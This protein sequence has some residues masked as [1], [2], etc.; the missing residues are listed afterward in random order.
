MSF[1]LAPGAVLFKIAGA[2]L[3]A[4]LPLFTVYLAAQTTTEL[5]NAYNGDSSAGNRALMLVVA[6]IAV[7]LVSVVWSNFNS[8]AQAML[9]YKV[10]L[11]VSDIMYER[12]LALDFWRYEDKAT[13]D[14]YDKAKR[15]SVFY[16]YVFDQLATILSDIVGMVSAIVA[17][18]LVVPWIALI[19]FV[20]LIPGVY[21]QFKLSRAQVEQW[22][23]NVTARRAQSNIEW[24]LL[25]P[26]NIVELRL[27][28]IVRFML[29]LRAKYR[30]QDER[31]RLQFEKNYL[32]KQIMS[33]L[34]ESGA[35]LISLIW[36]TL[37]IITH[38]Q[39]L[40]QFVYVQQ[41]V[42]RAIGSMNSL[43]RTISN[44][45]ED[46]AQL[47]E[48]QKFMEFPLAKNNDKRVG[49]VPEVITCDHVSFHY[50]GTSKKVLHDISLTI[51]RGQHIAIVGENGAGKSTLIKLLLGLFAPSS[52]HI[53]LDGTDLGEYSIDSWHRHLGV[54]QQSYL[55]YDFGTI[56]D[57]IYYGD[58]S[59][60]FDHTRYDKSVIQAEAKSFIDDLKHKENTYPAKWIVED[61]IEDDEL[62]T[63]L[64]G[65][66]WQRIA[67]AR[68]FYR[69][70]PIIILDEPTSAI[71][72]LAE[73]RIFKRLFE[74]TSK[75][76]VTIS[77]RLSTVKK[78]D[79][80]HVMEDGRIVET[81][82]HQE[83]V[84][85]KGSYYRLFES[86]LS[87]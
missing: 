37:E 75:T 40:G 35:E 21:V 32:G 11:K 4:V 18:L 44:I 6:A 13:A 41:I 55:E 19:V 16:S 22:N 31:K 5:A 53:R 49:A 8:Y 84:N 70:A 27:N 68:S 51:K 82:T 85:A 64:S 66:Q 29:D 23:K 42:S 36:I 56:R 74:D 12:F 73:S 10:E 60:P 76:I 87:E 17:L 62:A 52:G 59:E 54:L 15:F 79:I 33:S 86:Q 34:L 58:V 14:T 61:D 7:G 3:D 78:A 39:P 71:D 63:S 38:H 77:H 50:H 45:D 83:L 72:A 2:I 20:A 28:G 65:G 24:H 47:F 26:K 1:R 80:I 9:R 57:N 25:E 48:Y 81:G 30:D 67:L 43:V 69:D 46:L